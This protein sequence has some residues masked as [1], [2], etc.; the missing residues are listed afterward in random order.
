MWNNQLFIKI[1]CLFYIRM[2]LT[3][4]HGVSGLFVLL[5]IILMVKPIF[6][7]NM[8]NNVL[9]RV[10]LIAILLFF[11][12]NSVTLGLLVA[13]IIIIGTNISFVEGMKNSGLLEDSINKN[14]SNN[15]VSDQTISEKSDVNNNTNSDIKSSDKGKFDDSVNKAISRLNGNGITI[16]DDSQQIS[17]NIAPIQV[18]TSNYKMSNKGNGV[19]RITLAESMMSMDS[20][21]M[22]INKEV[23]KGGDV[24]AAEPN[25][26]KEGYMSLVH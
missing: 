22:P 26:C 7:N 20:K 23:F 11:A 6:Y 3:K 16:G 24:A 8:Y 21:I 4:M 1:Y 13:L 14:S 18:T 2:T 12:T 9:G 10:V 15:Q 19:D 25:I 17:T 5:V